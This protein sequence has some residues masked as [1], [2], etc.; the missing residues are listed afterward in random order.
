MY[1][2]QAVAIHI[3]WI[4]LWDVARNYKEGYVT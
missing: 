4:R 1:P 3:E 2:F